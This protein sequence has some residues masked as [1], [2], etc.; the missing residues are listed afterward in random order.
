LHWVFA[1]TSSVAGCILIEVKAAAALIPAHQAQ[2]LSYLRMGRFPIGLLMNFNELRLV[3]GLRLFVARAP[4]PDPQQ[5]SAAL[6]VL[7]GKKS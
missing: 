2:I 7:G 1:P 4:T 3:D 5:T 6:G